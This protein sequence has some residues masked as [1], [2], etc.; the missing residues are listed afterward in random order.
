MKNIL[1]T[2]LLLTAAINS[3]AEQGCPA[4]QYPIGGQGVAACA[5]I[6][7]ANPIV[8]QPRPNGKWLN[9][10]GA[11]ASDGGD[12]LGVSK[13]KLEKA[14]AQRE[15]LSKCNGLGGQ[16][17]KVEFVYENQCASIV[18][19][20]RGE[21]AISGMLAYAGAPTKDMASANALSLCKKNNSNASCRVI[22]TACT[23]PVFQRY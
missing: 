10:W 8:Q 7:T 18:E 1:L 3:H 5:P 15:A 23:E 12:N 6:P 21:N 2:C 11:I 20:Y 16:E 4:G 22:Y 9:T 14:D 17:C 13:D 19:P